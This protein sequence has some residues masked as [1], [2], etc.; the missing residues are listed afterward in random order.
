MGRKDKSHPGTV[1]GDALL[2]DAAC[3]KDAEGCGSW[4][5]HGTSQHVPGMGPCCALGMGGDLIHPPTKHS[6]CVIA[7]THAHSHLNPV[8]P[9]WIRGRISSQG[10][11][12]GDALVPWG[13][14]SITGVSWMPALSPGR[15]VVPGCCKTLGSPGFIPGCDGIMEKS[16][17]CSSPDGEHPTFLFLLFSGQRAPEDSYGMIFW[18]TM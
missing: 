11:C 4:M 7:S 14:R 3:C 1:P 6:A 17:W 12:K 13:V 15:V 16:W 9:P 5:D 10:V 2:T 18:G 8:W